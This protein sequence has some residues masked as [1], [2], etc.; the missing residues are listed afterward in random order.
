MALLTFGQQNLGMAGSKNLGRG[1]HLFVLVEE[2]ANILGQLSIL[3][4]TGRIE[5]SGGL[6]VGI[7]DFIPAPGSNRDERRQRLLAARDCNGLFIRSPV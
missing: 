5:R 2:P 7:A 3:G 4:I 6:S 1:I